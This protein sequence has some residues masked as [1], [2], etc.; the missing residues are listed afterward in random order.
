MA[1]S[2]IINISLIVLSTRAAYSAPKMAIAIM[3][4]ASHHVKR[5]TRKRAATALKMH[6]SSSLLIKYCMKLS[7]HF[8]SL[9]ESTLFKGILIEVK[10]LRKSSISP[11]PD[12]VSLASKVLV[13]ILKVSILR[14]IAFFNQITEEITLKETTTSGLALRTTNLEITIGQISLGMI[15]TSYSS[16]NMPIS[17][18]L[19]N[20]SSSSRII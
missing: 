13:L 10:T 16:V 9:K 14:C 4:V 15:I 19:S 18:I 20:Y 12:L 2:R 6:R 17:P 1:S 5:T 3:K 11:K 7:S 8:K